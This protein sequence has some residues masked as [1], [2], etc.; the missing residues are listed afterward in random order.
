M[1]D[2]SFSSIYFFPQ[3]NWMDFVLN[4]VDWTLCGLFPE[5]GYKDFVGTL[6]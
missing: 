3:L 5:Q 6:P 1:R 4:K 2:L